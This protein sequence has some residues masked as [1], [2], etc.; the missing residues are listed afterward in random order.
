MTKLY[1]FIFSFLLFFTITLSLKNNIYAYD[2]TLTPSQLYSSM[3]KSWAYSWGDWSTVQ[4]K[5]TDI[6]PHLE[7]YCDLFNS[8][9]RAVIFDIFDGRYHK[10]GIDYWAPLPDNGAFYKSLCS[11]KGYDY[12]FG[13]M[14]SKDGKYY[15]IDIYND[16]RPASSLGNY[17]FTCDDNETA[18]YFY[19]WTT[20]RPSDGSTLKI[21]YIKDGNNNSGYDS[22]LGYLSDVVVKRGSSMMLTALDTDV[23]NLI[24]RY[25]WSALTSNEESLDGVDVKIV[26]YRNEDKVVEKELHLGCPP[27]EYFFDWSNF[28]EL[29]L[30]DWVVGSLYRYEIYLRPTKGNSYGDYC[31]FNVNFPSS[32]LEQL[33]GTFDPTYLTDDIQYCPSVGNV[34]DFNKFNRPEKTTPIYVPHYVTNNRPADDIKDDLKNDDKVPPSSPSYNTVINNINNVVNNY[35]DDEGNSLI[36]SISDLFGFFKNF[37]SF[38]ALFITSVLSNF[39]FIPTWVINLIKGTILAFIVISIIKTVL[40]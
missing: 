10:C 20:L 39:T 29:N 12:L 17:R 5:S 8:E 30:K 7:A 14:C 21:L 28:V 13:H 37:L 35:D 6:I 26:F 4:N 27:N 24:D 15:Y 36:E 32:A 18:G 25:S 38:I 2:T 1:K 19:S 34:E 3:T 9:D 11:E 22:N 33:Q 31:F 40:N 16:F 23:T